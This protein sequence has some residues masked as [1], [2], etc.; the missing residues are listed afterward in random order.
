VL[1]GVGADLVLK[2]RVPVYPNIQLTH[3]ALAVTNKF[4]H[5]GVFLLQVGVTKQ[6]STTSEKWIF[7]G[8]T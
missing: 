1:V 6:F 8:G 2:V 7:H 3:A 4:M 5:S